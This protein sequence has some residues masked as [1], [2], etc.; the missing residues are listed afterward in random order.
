[1]LVHGSMD[2]SAS[3]ARLVPLLAPYTVVSYDRRGYGRSMA[4]GG[5]TFE[6]HV[7]DLLEIIAT[8][9]AVVFGHS[10]GA[11]VALAAAAIAPGCISGVMAWEPSM[12]WLDYWPSTT[13]GGAAREGAPPK[14]AAEIFL[15]RMLGDERYSAMPERIRAAR[16]EEGH[17]LVSEMSSLTRGAPFSA[18]D[19]RVPTVMASGSES[20]PWSRRSVRELAEQLPLGSCVETLGASHAA[21]RSHPLALSELLVQLVRMVSIS[22]SPAEAKV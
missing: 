13:P 6:D 15:R 4:A 16:L 2:R 18:T 11:D 7:D 1:M 3:F 19:I 12:P 8:R 5:G 17:A 21:H 14:E 9:R 22:A 20:S 10:Y